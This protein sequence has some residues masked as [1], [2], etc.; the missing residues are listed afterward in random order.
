MLPWDLVLLLLP[1]TL[2]S[3]FFL[4]LSILHVTLCSLP[5]LRPCAPYSFCDLLV[6]FPG[7][8]HASL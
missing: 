3:L 7:F 4:V 8:G 2:C 6:S 1:V 5:P